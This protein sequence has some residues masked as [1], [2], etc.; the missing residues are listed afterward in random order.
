[1]PKFISANTD[2]SERIHLWNVAISARNAKGSFG[3]QALRN[4]VYKIRN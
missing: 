3:G 2:E 4:L 1:M